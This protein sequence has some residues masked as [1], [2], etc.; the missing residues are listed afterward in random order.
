[1]ADASIGAGSGSARHALRLRCASCLTRL[2]RPYLRLDRRDPCKE[3]RR[4]WHTL[5]CM[6]VRPTRYAFGPRL[7]ARDWREYLSS[8]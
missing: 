3:A 6:R 8:P 4:L 2:V 7:V 1:M 5:L